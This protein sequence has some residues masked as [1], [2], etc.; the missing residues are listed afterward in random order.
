MP[1]YA[2]T[3]SR[4]NPERS[5]IRYLHVF[6]RQIRRSEGQKGE[7]PEALPRVGLAC[8]VKNASEQPGA[9]LRVD[10]CSPACAVDYSPTTM[11]TNRLHILCQLPRHGR[12]H[13]RTRCHLVLRPTVL[14][15]T[16]LLGNRGQPACVMEG[17][18]SI[19]APL[20]GESAWRSRFP[21]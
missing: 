12:V 17:S 1:A 19:K 5:M 16:R 3:G 8:S 18:A 6:R 11:N 4:L 20:Q 7:T 21:A 13:C 9:M 14:R 10:D 15:H 2:S